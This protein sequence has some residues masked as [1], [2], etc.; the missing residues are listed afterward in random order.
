MPPADQTSS[1][2]DMNVPQRAKADFLASGAASR[3]IRAY[4][5]SLAA[6]VVWV[7]GIATIISIMGIF[8]Y[9]LV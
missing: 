9:L 4:I 2:D 7:G 1:L 6:G 3:K 8:V 5:D